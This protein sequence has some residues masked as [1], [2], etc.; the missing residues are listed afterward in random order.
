MSKFV[1]WI[2][3]HPDDIEVFF[4]L[5]PLSENDVVYDL[6]SG[7]GRLL[8]A[9]L[10]HGA[11]RCVGIELDPELIHTATQTASEKG[12]ADKVHFIRGGH[13]GSGLVTGHGGVVLSLSHGISGTGDQV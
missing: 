4:E 9:A 10:E 8:F 2:P 3:T 11:G 12:V 7:D 5:T 13:P 1:D 6:G